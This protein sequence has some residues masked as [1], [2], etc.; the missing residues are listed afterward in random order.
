MRRLDLKTAKLE[1]R[2]HRALPHR[3][4]GDAQCGCR[5]AISCEVSGQ[6]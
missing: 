2:W 4:G 5:L 1:R 6:L 3:I